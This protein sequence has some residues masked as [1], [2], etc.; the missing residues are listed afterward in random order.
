MTDD[1]GQWTDH[2]R[3]STRGE[4]RRVLVPA[5]R[6]G[7]TRP[8]P[9]KKVTAI[10]LLSLLPVLVACSSSKEPMQPAT[11]LA[12]P[13]TATAAPYTT[14][15][16]EPFLEV[17]MGDPFTLPPGMTL[18]VTRH[19]HLCDRPPWDVHAIEADETGRLSSASLLDSL[20]AGIERDRPGQGERQPYILGAWA[21]PDGSEVLVEVC[22]AG[23]CGDKCWKA[24]PS[25]DAVINLY[26]SRDDGRTWSVYA[27]L[28]PP[29]HTFGIAEDGRVI[30]GDCMAKTRWLLPGDDALPYPSESPENLLTTGRATRF[31]DGSLVY[32][33]ETGRHLV[34]QHSDGT[35]VEWFRLP[36]QISS[37]TFGPF[38]SDTQ[39]FVTVK[40]TPYVINWPDHQIHPL[41]SPIDNPGILRIAGIRHH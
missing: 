14:A 33:P 2:P 17:S 26:S 5:R 31:A 41:D 12:P 20:P 22:I 6:R 10:V 13:A 30:A 15:V 24:I 32:Q 38:L 19:C 18:Y 9:H 8:V 16:R 29:E 28:H 21:R 25:D 34:R 35:P 23:R 1:S 7:Y 37:I 40:G 3:V 39:Q 27:T 36:K 4:Q 11:P